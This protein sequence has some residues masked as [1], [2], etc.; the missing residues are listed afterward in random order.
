MQFSVNPNFTKYL[1]ERY[2]CEPFF[3]KLCVDLIS[4]IGYQWVFRKDLISPIWRKFPENAEIC[5]VNNFFPEGNHKNVWSTYIQNLFIRNFFAVKCKALIV[6]QRWILLLRGEISSFKTYAVKLL[7]L[8]SWEEEK[9]LEFI[10]D[11]KS[12]WSQYGQYNFAS[13]I[14][15]QNIE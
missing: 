2:F 11:V 1:K 10:I 9:G 4:R 13:N 14:Q 5:L 12:I 7:W 6:T 15:F 8:N 3:W